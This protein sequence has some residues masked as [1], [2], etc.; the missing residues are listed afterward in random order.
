VKEEFGISFAAGV[1]KGRI[2]P[3]FNIPHF[4]EDISDCQGLLNRPQTQI[5]LEGRNRVGVARLNVNGNQVE[6]IVVKKFNII[7]VNKLKS[8]FIF[9]KAKK[10]WR[11]ATG[12][13]ERGIDTPVPIAYLEKRRKIFLDQCFFLSKKVG[14]INEIRSFFLHSPQDEL[15]PLLYSLAHHL[16][17]CHGKGMLHKDLSDGNILV[18]KD[19]EGKFKF[20]FIDTNRIRFLKR[21][22][23]FKRVKNLIRLG[24]PSPLQSTFLKHYL[25]RDRRLR[26]LWFWYRLNKGVFSR[27]LTFKRKLRLKH[28]AKKLRIQ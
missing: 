7:G 23:V 16:K 21:I 27:Y 13:I 26:L 12:L 9:S 3:D 15:H 18:K 22:N 8:P 17:Y 24:I 4:I 5:L 28:L 25:E 11:G 1:F 20:Y 14:E 6:E 2:H 10:S 19:E